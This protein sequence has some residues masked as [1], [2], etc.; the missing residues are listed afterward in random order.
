MG[1]RR[2]EGDLVIDRS[3]FA[4]G[5]RIHSG[6]D[7]HPYSEYNAM[8]DAL[9]F[10]DHLC[11]IIVDPRSGRP[12]AHK[13]IP[14]PGYRIRNELR[15]T[16]KACRGRYSWPNVQVREE[17]G[18]TT[19]HLG[20]ILSR[21]CSPRNISLVLSHPYQAFTGAFLQELKAAGIEMKGSMRLG[22][23]PAGARE[24]LTHYSRPLIE[25]L[26][27]TNK[28]SNN[29]YAR[30][31]FLLLGAKRFGAPATLKKGRRAVKAIL[32]ARG[33]LGEETILD[34]GCG[35]SRKTRTTAR[36]LHRL[37]QDAYRSYGWTWL[38]ALAIAGVDG[39]VNRRYR[40]S[41]VR[42]H[43]WLKTGTLKDAK[44]IAGYV[45]GRSGTLYNVVILYNG[46]ERWKGKL[47][48]DQILEWIVK[49]K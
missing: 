21:R 39:T 40:H 46:P 34:N 12:E 6:F 20:G 2:I 22:R 27:K 11:R 1:V 7:E 25:I 30:H 38:G 19:V 37:L 35:L 28:K 32:G 42:R 49:N 16:D 13:K 24:L 48:Q 45:K 29:L 4:V 26:A 36:A 33:I 23:L 41:P 8:P 18:T 5:D 43:A 3:F 9:M 15:L 17:N 47:L 14:D 10:D 31:I 44:N